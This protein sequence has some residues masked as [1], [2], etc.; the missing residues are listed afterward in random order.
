MSTSQ[1]AK[2]AVLD[3]AKKHGFV[4]DEY[5][6]RLRQLDPK[7]ER[8]FQES[9]LAMGEFNG[10]MIKTLAKNIYS[11]DARFVFE[12]LQNADDSRFQRAR[13]RGDLPSIAFHVHPG[14]IVVECNEDGFTKRDLSAICAVGQSTKSGSHGYIGAKGIGFKSVFS[15]AW[16]VYIQSGYFS[17][18]FKHRKGDLGLGM[19]LPIW[20][21]GDDD[22]DT[23][24]ELPSPSQ[25]TRMT[26]HLHDKG[27][28][29][30]LEHLHNII[31]KQL[32]G[33]QPTCL[34]FLRNLRRIQ[35][36]SY[37][38]G[39]RT[40]KSREFR[41]IGDAENHRVTLESTVTDQGGEATTEERHFHV[42]RHMASNLSRSQNRELSGPEEKSRAFSEAE[43]VLAFPLTGCSAPVV[44]RQEIFAFLPVEDSTFKFLINSDFDTTASRQRIV[45]TSRRNIDL[46]D[47]IAAAFLTAV[48]QFCEH[49]S[50]CYTWPMFLPA[51]DDKLS[52]FW[53]GLHDRIK[54]LITG[55]PVLRSRHSAHLRRIQDVVI[56]ADDATDEDG[57]PLLDCCVRDP[58]LSDAY[59]LSSRQVL[60][61]YGLQVLSLE[62]SVALL[63]SDLNSSSSKMKAK[64]TSDGWHSATAK[65][66][67][68]CFERGFQNLISE[69]KDLPL[70]PLASGAWVS[71]NSGVVHMPITIRGIPIPPGLD[72]RVL[73]S[74]A[75]KNH[76]RSG[77][78]RHLGAVEASV[79]HVRSAVLKVYSPPIRSHVGVAVSKAQLHF[80][81][82]AS[83]LEKTPSDLK[84]IYVYLKVGP[85]AYPHRQDVYLPG[86]HAYGPEALLEPAGDAPGLQV[87]FLHPIYLEDVPT[88]PGSQ[89][90]SW[91]EWLLKHLDIRERLRIV[92]RNGDSLSEIWIYVASQRPGKL[93]G[94]LEH[95]WQDEGPLVQ[96]SSALTSALKDTDAKRL[97][98]LSFH[99]DCTLGS[100]WLPLPGLQQKKLRFMAAS[101]PFPFLEL[102]E[103][104]S[105]VQLTAKWGFL[106]Q[107]GVGIGVGDE[108]DFLLDVLYWINPTSDETYEG[109]ALDVY[110]TIQAK[111]FGLE[112]QD[113]KRAIRKIRSFIDKYALVVAPSDVSHTMDWVARDDCLWEGPPGMET[114]P[115]V[116]CS[117]TCLCGDDAE[118]LDLVSRFFK[119]TLEI[120]D[121]SS[122]HIVQELDWMRKHDQGDF[123]RIYGF[124]RYLSKIATPTQDTR[125]AF[126]SK[127]RIFVPQGSSR[128]WYKTSQCL[129]SSTADI[130]GK[131]TL[132]D[133]YE[134]LKDFFLEI[135]GVKTLTAQMVYDDL[136][137]TTPEASVERVKNTIES[138]SSLLRAEPSS[139]LDPRELIQAAFLPVRYPGGPVV[140]RSAEANFAIVDREYLGELFRDRIKLLDYS[141]EDVRRLTPFFRWAGLEHCYLSRCTREITSA[142]S[143]STRP[144]KMPSR[145][146]RSK[147]HAILRVAATFNSPRYEA[148]QNGLYQLLRT[149]QM[150]ETDRIS[151][152]FSISQD[153]HCIDVEQAEGDLHIDE[154]PSALTVFVPS[155][156]KKQE[157]CYHLALPKSLGAWLMRDPTTQIQ[158]TVEEAAVTT[159]A[160]ILNASASEV[161]IN[162]ILDGC[163]IVNVPLPREAGTDDEAE[164]DTEAEAEDAEEDGESAAGPPGQLITPDG[165]SFEAWDDDDGGDSS[166]VISTSV[167][168]SRLARRDPS[169]L[170]AVAVV[171]EPLPSGEDR[172]YIRILDG[173]LK[174][175]RAASFPSKGAFSMA[176]LQAA[177]PAIDHAAGFGSFDGFDGRDQIGSRFRSSTKLERDKKIGAAGELYVFELL[178]RLE[179]A[180]S[181]WGRGNWQSSIRKY[182]AEHQ[183]YADME[184]WYGIETAD[185][186]YADSE[187]DLTA[188]LVDRGY[189]DGD[190]W[191]GARPRY[192]IEVKSTTGPCGVPFY[193]SKGQYQMMKHS[194]AGTN[195]RKVYMIARVFDI[196]GSRTG[197]RVYV[198]PEQMR[199]D[200]ALAFTAEAWSVV[201]GPSA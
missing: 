141:L 72:M 127:H 151:T 96:N 130:Q 88:L 103:A 114:R 32:D 76:D 188:L 59:R 189:L 50:L 200:N 116:K 102:E 150:L 13:V 56:L 31:L 148:D 51:S 166:I 129:W 121:A 128:G 184:P 132:N 37:D 89:D 83:R 140:L 63:K 84:N 149:A 170:R 54:Q 28:P 112:S 16:K 155:N 93:L 126:E 136:K 134:D 7:I 29:E 197:M 19:I 26:L 193:M 110:S 145:R 75:A 99:S 169:M 192:L 1:D 104:G 58:Y 152:M 55:T 39:G 25:V 191:R 174:A 119:Q 107:F 14:R 17:F 41:Q 106:E 120:P 90:P 109:K 201:P 179:P 175:A 168:A 194:H 124:Y 36:I 171:P 40:T 143:E 27:D 122:E 3:I 173:V 147:A 187:G 61:K 85:A 98:G 45:T 177:L 65:L 154:T 178:S 20:V 97:C 6:R 142:S 66:F 82:L 81:Y 11:S 92:D 87:A 30:E 80:L 35:V 78:F 23:Q 2:Q 196:G 4:D 10:H 158:D 49:E 146:L 33:L 73:D 105:A 64:S 108:V 159:L 67:S 77:L 131:V 71:A 135:L 161:V 164:T 9:F 60:Q 79:S 180:L 53:S 162:S 68:K 115:A 181:G 48:L 185:I 62:I 47:G 139:R 52:Q 22:N 46:L 198:D 117:Y 125:L 24:N 153:G 138:F 160:A 95:A 199:L 182:V 74:S 186:T 111:L 57:G 167:A 118:K 86:G 70:L 113:R 12:L 123:D 133:H 176:A 94:L 183:D 15:A 172:Q 137:Q 156:K 42:T 18:Y 165:S 34:L 190:L 43:V 69:L 195:R 91:R 5:W 163:G 101:D 8:V 44:G 157:V 144:I 100:T 38:D 21:D